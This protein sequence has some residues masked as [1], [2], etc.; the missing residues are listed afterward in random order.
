MALIININDGIKE[1]SQL[2]SK[3]HYQLTIDIWWASQGKG[4]FVYL[5]R[6]LGQH[7]TIL[8]RIENYDDLV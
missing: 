5:N 6:Y 4:I 1:P 2:A 7:G 8:N 3:L